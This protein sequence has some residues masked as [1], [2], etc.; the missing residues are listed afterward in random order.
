MSE[1]L[2]PTEEDRMSGR[3][4]LGINE[5]GDL[6][7]TWWGKTSHVPLYGWC[8]GDDIEDLDIWTPVLVLRVPNPPGRDD[9]IFLLS[10]PKD[11]PTP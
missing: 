2:P 8:H 11:T 7:L 4:Y 5:E 3:P 9:P 10:D 6:R 1:W